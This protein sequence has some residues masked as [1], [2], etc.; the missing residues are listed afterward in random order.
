[1]SDKKSRS[2]KSGPA[3]SGID[4]AS[5][6]VKTATANIEAQTGMSVDE[7]FAMMGGWGPLKHGQMVSRLKEELGLGHGHASMLV[8]DYRERTEGGGPNGDPLDSIYS[9]KKADLR[10]L[11]E[12]VVARLQDVGDFE[13]A[14]KKAYVSLRRSKQFATVGPGSRGR[15]EVGINHRGA[16]GTDRLEVLPAGQ[17][18]THRVYLT[19]ADEVDDEFVGYVRAAFE[20]AG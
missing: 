15:L 6:Y 13:V 10:P 3:K 20:A 2:E 12:T 18:C 5:Q 9:G 19:A 7:I 11:H 1:M 4:K 14:P 17:M 8:H 16:E